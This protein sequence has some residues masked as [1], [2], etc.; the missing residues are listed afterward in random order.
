M[1]AVDTNVLARFYVD[2]PTDPDA[3]RQRRAARRLLEESEAVFVPITVVLELEWVTRALYDFGPDDF[4]RVVEHL[5]G[6]PNVTVEDWT[7]V[8][9]AAALHRAGL[10]YADALHLVRSTRCERFFTFDDRGFARRANRLGALPPVEV[11]RPVRQRR[12]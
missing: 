1:I 8:L 7:S 6:L 10:D 9:D 3:G 5:V 2:D 11:P 4:G 12:S